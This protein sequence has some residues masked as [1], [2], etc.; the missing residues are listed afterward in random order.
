LVVI[1]PS[2]FKGG[3][4]VVRHSGEEK[5]FDFAQG[6]IN[7]PYFV[8]FYADCQHGMLRVSLS[9]FRCFRCRCMLCRRLFCRCRRGRRVVVGTVSITVFV[10]VVAVVVFLVDVV[11][12][13]S[14][15]SSP[16]SLSYSAVIK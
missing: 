4:L 10:V 5:V 13:V 14:S 8:A 6:C 16:L 2:D 15:S 1:L 3:Q 7:E 9:S 12:V 11:I